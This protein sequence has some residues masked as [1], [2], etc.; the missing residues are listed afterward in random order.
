MKVHSGL[1]C[2]SEKEKRGLEWHRCS[3]ILKA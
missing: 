2:V 3:I 1:F